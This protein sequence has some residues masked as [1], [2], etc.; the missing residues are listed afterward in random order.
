MGPWANSGHHALLAAALILV[1]Q[2]AH[3]DQR[4]PSVADAGFEE[5]FDAFNLLRWQK[6]DGWS[7]GNFMDCA[8]DA[9]N[10]NLRAGR[11]VLSITD[12]PRAGSPYSCAEYRTR[13]PY[14]YGTYSVRLKAVPLD[15]VMTTFSTYTG[16]PFGDPWDEITVG[17]NGKD[18]TKLEVNYVAK[19]IGRH[20]TLIDLGFDA[21]QGFH[22]YGFEWRADAISWLVDGQVVHTVQG[23]SDDLPHTPGRV[24][25]QL[26][27]AKGD[28]SWLR[29]FRYP[30]TPPSAEV[31]W[32]QY[33][34]AGPVPVN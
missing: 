30:G 24:Y 7:N 33:R 32:V 14:G 16:Q 1:T 17:I 9:R 10:I 27:N 34:E 6:S 19:G 5:R 2:A 31:A 23:I 11:L 15:G 20:D 8:W 4:R 21:A 28:T 3:A 25:L 12:R 22:T 26:W 18:T 13:K 29:R